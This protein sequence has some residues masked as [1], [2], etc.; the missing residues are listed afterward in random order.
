MAHF[1]EDDFQPDPEPLPIDNDTATLDALADA[2]ETDGYAESMAWCDSGDH[3][4]PLGTLQV[5]TGRDANGNEEGWA[6]CK[7]C[8]DAAAPFDQ[9]LP[10][11]DP[12]YT[13]QAFDHR[14]TTQ[15]PNERDDYWQ[16]F[17]RSSAGVLTCDQAYFIA[18]DYWCGVAA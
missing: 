8:S 6:C 17:L 1:L 7:S 14:K 4:A 3:F 13:R 12:I 16:E 5:T 9:H 10:E 18:Q 11:P 15:T 2:S